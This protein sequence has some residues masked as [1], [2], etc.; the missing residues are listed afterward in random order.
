MR[1]IKKLFAV[2]FALVLV[3]GCSMKTEYNMKI[4]DDKSMDFS[5]ILGLDDELIEGMASMDSSD[6]ELEYEDELEYDDELDSDWDYTEETEEDLS[7]QEETAELTEEQKWEYIDS[8]F[9]DSEDMSYEKYGFKKE[10]YE[11]GNYKGYKFVTTISNIDD[12][13]GE[14]ANF[15]L[16]D[17]QDLSKSVVF[18][19]DGNKYKANFV[20]ENE[21]SESAEG[22]EVAFDIKYVVTLPNKAISHNATE[23]S[24]DGKTLTWDLLDA[25]SKNIE[26]E[27]SFEKNNTALYLGIGIGAVVIVAAIVVCIVLKK[28]RNK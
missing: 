18:T 12:I 28:K 27:F 21:N 10:K 4:N 22:M 2:I 25:K 11:E 19:K 26:F 17:F 14:K 23:V 7:S 3:T 6:S 1:S 16:T 8:M 24:K 20:L 15:D 5:V 9:E 13:S